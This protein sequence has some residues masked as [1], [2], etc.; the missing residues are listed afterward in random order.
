MF[1]MMKFLRKLKPSYIWAVWSVALG[2]PDRKVDSFEVVIVRTILF[3]PL[4][5]YAIV[6]TVYPIVEPKI[7]ETIQRIE[8]EQLIDKIKEIKIP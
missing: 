3:L 8:Y 7:S 6:N 1:N 4:W 5:I 2:I